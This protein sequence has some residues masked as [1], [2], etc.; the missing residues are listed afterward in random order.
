MGERLIINFGCVQS[1]LICYGQYQ[2]KGKADS[3]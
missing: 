1:Y 2:K 3:R